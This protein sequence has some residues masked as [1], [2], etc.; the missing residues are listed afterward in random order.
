LSK[1]CRKVDK[2]LFTFRKGM[3]DGRRRGKTKRNSKRAGRKKK[4][5]EVVINFFKKGW[6]MEEVEENQKGKA[7][8]EIFF[9]DMN[10]FKKSFKNGY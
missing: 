5:K 7:D 6:K 8:E 1:N 10:R 3:K 9:F 4:K 2:Y